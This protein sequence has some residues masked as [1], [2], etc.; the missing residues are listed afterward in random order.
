[1]ELNF[2]RG[3]CYHCLKAVV[4]LIP[5]FRLFEMLDLFRNPVIG[6]YIS[7]S[8]IM[9]RLSRLV[10][11]ISRTGHLDFMEPSVIVLLCNCLCKI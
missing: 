11:A 4:G 6:F 3:V 8:V 5:S 1:M 2:V 10:Y 9:W 7:S